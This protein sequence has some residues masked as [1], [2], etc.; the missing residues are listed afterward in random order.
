MS[1]PKKKMWPVFSLSVS[2]DLL[3]ITWWFFMYRLDVAQGWK[4]GTPSEDQS[5]CPVVI[6]LAR[7]ASKSYYDDVSLPTNLHM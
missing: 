4:Y 1:I 5:H 6:D 3:N 7:L 2:K